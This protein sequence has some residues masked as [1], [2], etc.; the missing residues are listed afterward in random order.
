LF[1]DLLKKIS[2]GSIKTPRAA[3]NSAKDW[4][5]KLSGPL[6]QAPE[7]PCEGTISK[8]G[9]STQVGKEYGPAF[10]KLIDYLDGTGYEINSLGGFVDRDVRGKPGQKS[11]HAMGGA[12]DINPEANPMGAELITDMPAEISK[13]AASLGLGWGGNWKSKKDAMHFSAARSEGGKML[14]AAN[15]AILSG[16]MSGYQPNL[17]MHGTE[18]IVP[19]NTPA[20]TG[21]SVTNDTT[22]MMEQLAKM[23]ELAAIFRNQLS[24]DQKI[25]SYSS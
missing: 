4:L 8:S 17:T 7:P 10:Q 5:F 14:S 21:N 9:K 16:P 3:H 25:L 15:G 1:D 11:V 18:A 12:I 19:I 20:T 23:E 22:M 2:P 13:V 6:I 24:I